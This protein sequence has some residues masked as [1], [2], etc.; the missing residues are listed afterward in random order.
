MN[1]QRQRMPRPEAPLCV[2]L[3]RPG[4]LYSCSGRTKAT[5]MRRLG[6]EE[7]VCPGYRAGRTDPGISPFF[8]WSCKSESCALQRAGVTFALHLRLGPNVQCMHPNDEMVVSMRES[9]DRGPFV[10]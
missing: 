10:G 8:A 6:S 7:V 3:A 2:D 9:H 4:S 1:H 5:S